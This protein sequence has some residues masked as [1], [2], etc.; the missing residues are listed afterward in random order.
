MATW[1]FRNL[2]SANAKRGK[3]ACMKGQVKACDTTQAT[4]NEEWN[5][6][7]RNIRNT[8]SILQHISHIKE[9]LPLMKQQTI[10]N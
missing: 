1:D 4:Q 8:E 7:K 6:T 9:E 3:S 2:K 10:E 5:L